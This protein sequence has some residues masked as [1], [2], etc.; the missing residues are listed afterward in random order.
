MTQQDNRLIDWT[1]AQARTKYSA[2]ICLMLEHDIY[3]MPADKAMRYM[4]YFISDADHLIGLARTFIIGGVGYDYWQNRWERYERIADLKD[5][6]TSDLL[7]SKVIY[8]RS[9]EDLQYFRYLQ[10]KLRRRLADPKYMWERSLEWLDRA[11]D[12][13]K[14][15]LF[16]DDLGKCRLYAGEAAFYQAICMACVNC[17][18]FKNIILA[19][20]LH[21][22]EKLPD[23]FVDAYV[24]ISELTTPDELR[25]HVRDM[26]AVTKAFVKANAPAKSADAPAVPNYK[27]LA[28]W[29]QECIYNFRR[30]Y[31]ICDNQ[32]PADAYYSSMSL[33][34]DFDYL[35]KDFNLEG[36]DLL[37]AFDA[38]DIEGF[39][40]HA[41]TIEQRIVDAIET[42][43]VEIEAYE[44]VEDFIARNP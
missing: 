21:S 19:M 27:H 34:G 4:K 5:F 12:E 30:L 36:L 13:Y 10:A 42:N 40:A 16:E 25:S 43:G 23:G 8:S 44:N 2:D 20:E 33:Q 39:K 15:M 22:L 28:E 14:N 9:E 3:S 17:T 41:R 37:G 32:T 1:L 38:G 31:W 26:L 6:F 24:R 35:M 11:V 18:Y 7:D 29:Y